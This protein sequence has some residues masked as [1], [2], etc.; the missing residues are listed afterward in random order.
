MK[1][2]YTISKGRVAIVTGGGS[3]I[4]K[5]NALA[6]AAAGAN[7]VVVDLSEAA[8]NQTVEEINAMEGVSAIAV[9]GDT[10][11]KETAQKAA[12]AA[13]EKYGRIDIL[14][15]AAGFPRDAMIHKMPEEYWD[16]VL[17]VDLKGYFLM[18]QAVLPHMRAAKYGRIV[19]I[20]SEACHG[21]RSQCAYSSAKAGIL[22]LSATAALEGAKYNITCNTI[23]PGV[24]DTP[25]LRRD[26]PQEY[27]QPM[28]DRI[29]LGH[30][31]ATTDDIAM[32]V[33][34]FSCD[35]NTYITGQIM[36]IDGGMQVGV[37]N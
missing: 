3:G 24:V 21:N 29:P 19:N 26:C 17:R 20:S 22:G 30:R 13:M 35:E 34:F 32:A 1:M 33:F 10:G 31:A 14:L 5:R 11:L 9:I 28:L 18:I 7:V 36:E 23:C 8:A 25:A 37:H 12:A 6:Y 2:E 4:G 27:L 15:N 16:D